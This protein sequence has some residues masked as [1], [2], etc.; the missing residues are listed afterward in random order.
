[1][2][3]SFRR[4]LIVLRLAIVNRAHRSDG[5]E[6]NRAAGSFRLCF[7]RIV[8]EGEKERRKRTR[9][10]RKKEKPTKKIDRDGH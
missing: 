10:E 5:L 8:S 7:S 1:M 9:R 3:P 4:Y 6:C 2:K